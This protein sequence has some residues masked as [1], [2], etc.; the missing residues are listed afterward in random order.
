MS[1][2]LLMVSMEWVMRSVNELGNWDIVTE[3]N[4]RFSLVATSYGRVAVVQGRFQGTGNV[5]CRGDM[6]EG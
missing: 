5:E 4:T 6:G 2:L 3:L 1:P